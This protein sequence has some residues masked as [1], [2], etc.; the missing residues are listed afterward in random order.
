MQR[1]QVTPNTVVSQP[2]SYPYYL[3][4]GNLDHL[5]QGWQIACEWE[6]PLRVPNLLGP[7]SAIYRV[8]AVLY[9]DNSM[10]GMLNSAFVGART[11]SDL[12]LRKKKG[13]GSVKVQQPSTAA[14]LAYN[15]H[16]GAV[17]SMDQGMKAYNIALKSSRWYMRLFFWNLDLVAW[18]AWCIAAW[19]T[20]PENYIHSDENVYRPFRFHSGSDSPHRLF[21]EALGDSLICKAL[22]DANS[23]EYPCFFTPRRP[24][25]LGALWC[26]RKCSAPNC[27][28]AC[29]SPQ[30]GLGQD[31]HAAAPAPS[32]AHTESSFPQ[33]QCTG[34]Q[35]IKRMI[36][37]KRTS[38]ELPQGLRRLREPVRGC[39]ECAVNLCKTCRKIWCHDQQAMPTTPPHPHESW[40]AFAELH[41]RT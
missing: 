38:C 32:Q 16:Y 3:P 28:G 4:P 34:C 39:C 25:A 35:F 33:K 37:K 13:N 6:R 26:R 40:Q 18:N 24:K 19:H 30:L 23:R 12:I 8:G 14:H 1:G 10:F 7:R 41:F 5:P 15:S 36:L 27:N 29:Y 11:P 21:M 22:T 2:M 31:L 9:K 17:D 20:M